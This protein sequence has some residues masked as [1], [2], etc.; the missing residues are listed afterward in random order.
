MLIFNKIKYRVRISYARFERQ[1]HIVRQTACGYPLRN[2]SHPFSQKIPI[3]VQP[4]CS[5]SIHFFYFF[6]DSAYK[7]VISTNR[8]RMNQLFRCKKNGNFGFCFLSIFWLLFSKR[9]FVVYF[10]I[11]WEFSGKE[12]IR[13]YQTDALQAYRNEIHVL[14]E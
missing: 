9:L 4:A 2:I 10:P 5:G 7:N 11:C 1:T 6:I 3:I 13:V 12:H 14:I 8:H